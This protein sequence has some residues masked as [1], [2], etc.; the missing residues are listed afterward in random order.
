MKKITNKQAA[1]KSISKKKKKWI[2]MGAALFLLVMA[3]CYTV[4]IAPLLEKEQWI[5]KESAVEKGTLTVGVSESG[6]LDYG[7]S[8]IEY[9][10]DLD[11]SDD[12]DDDDEED[13]ETVR[14]YLK[15]EEIYTAAGQRIEEGDALVKFTGDSVADVRRLLESALIDA[16]TDYNEAEAKYN[17][18]VLEAETTF[19][20]QKVESR[21]ALSIYENA[22]ASV[23]NDITAIQVQLDQ[24]NGNLSLLE[25]KLADAQE[26]CDDALE[27]YEAAREGMEQADISHTENFLTSQ[28]AYLNA[29]TQYQNAKSALDQAKQ[30]LDDNSDEI[31]S[32]EKKLAAAKA[33]SSID[34]LEVEESYLESV[35]QGDNAETTYNAQIE[36][37]KETLKEAE[38]KKQQVEEQLQAFEAFVGEDGK[39]YAQDSGIVTQVAYEEG[40]SLI[41]TGVIL[42]YATPEDMTISVDVTQEDVVDFSVGDKVDIAF[43]AYENT[44]FEGTILSIDTTATSENSNTVS[45]TVVIGVEGDTELLYGGMTADITFVTEEK[46]EV[47]YISRKA[48]VEENGRKYVYRRTALGGRELTEVETGISNGVS[49]EILSGL[50]EGDT[51]YI[52]SRVSSEADVEDTSMGVEQGQTG[53]AVLSGEMV[54]PGGIEMPGGIEIQGGVEMQGGMEMPGGSG[55]MEMPGGGQKT[56]REAR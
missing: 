49:V 10:L 24:R 36:S 22:S 38:E 28:N 25:E 4:F 54:L 27:E 43:T 45:Y 30:N 6:A 46:E 51:I 21:Y 40:D 48:I 55:G 50:S 11:V 2:A 26:A 37:L 31:I 3:A 9:N 7:I 15:I 23:S 39:L 41:Q 14:K 12:D 35:I 16:K 33:K 13:E 32:L 44:H 56:G 19:D 17:L 20:T 18:S 53:E 34:K 8:S 47:L 42:S 1:W 52:A 5:Y 29:Q